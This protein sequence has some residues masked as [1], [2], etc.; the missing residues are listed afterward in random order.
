[1][2]PS[3]LLMRHISCDC[4]QDHFCPIRSVVIGEHVL[5]QLPSLCSQYHRILLVADQNTYACCGES[6]AQLLG[7]R[8]VGQLIYQSGNH[9]LVPDRPAADR[10]QAEAERCSADFFVGIGSGVINDL[11]KYVSFQRS[12]AYLIVATAP[13]MDGYASSG[14]AMIFDGMKVTFPTHTPESILGDTE[15]L[16]HAPH[17]M[18]LSGFGDIIG[19]YSALCDWELAA[20]VRG[21]HFCRFLYDIVQNMTDRIAAQAEQI[22]AGQPQAIGELTE[23]LVLSGI[24]LSLL[25]ST[26]PGSGSE[27]HLSHFFEITGLIHNLPYLFHGTDVAYSTVVTA[28]LRELLCSLPSP[29]FHSESAETR[30]LAWQRIYGAHSKDIAQ[31]Q[32]ESHS[33]EA[34]D[35]AF[36]AAHWE[37]IRAILAHCPPAAAILQMLLRAGFAPETLV[38]F[39]GEEKIR[40]AAFYGKDLK[41]RYS[42]LWPFYD[43]FSGRQTELILSPH[44]SFALSK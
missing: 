15:V 12:H 37:E 2:I 42:V 29:V 43:L 40:D 5:P 9:F 1:M 8:C 25:G 36:Y 14:A 24:T 20:L 34:E 32:T 31:L 23:A 7:E 21:E 16:C 10:L 11:C 27:H 17:D 3:S 4:G 18:I 28:S 39:Y 26:R 41:N 30:M 13:S 6:V 22:A 35:P 38:H 33:Y 19:K 44:A